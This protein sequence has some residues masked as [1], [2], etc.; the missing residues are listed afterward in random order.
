[1]AARQAWSGRR[2]R[3]NT[4]SAARWSSTGG[5]DSSR[6]KH[7][8][9]HYHGTQR[10]FR[11]GSRAASWMIRSRY[12]WM[13]VCECVCVSPGNSS[14]RYATPHTRRHSLDTLHHRM[15]GRD[16][17]GL[18]GYAH[19]HRCGNKTLW[20]AS[21]RAAE[22]QSCETLHPIVGPTNAKYSPEHG[23][24]HSPSRPSSLCSPLP[25]RTVLRIYSRS[26]TH[27]RWRALESQSAHGGHLDRL[28]RQG[29]SLAGGFRRARSSIL[30]LPA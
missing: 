28:G 8:F 2:S 10:V 3:R 9:N 11:R 23:N 6:L 15:A 30:T 16:A 4:V 13:G 7:T 1:M 20:D 21:C 22:L 27:A 12:M 25:G 29:S 19:H 17:G 26:L 24:L 5:H 18:A 14:R